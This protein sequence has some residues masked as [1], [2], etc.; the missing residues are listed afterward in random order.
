MIQNISL[1]SF[2][3]NLTHLTAPNMSS[4]RALLAKRASSRLR[5][6]VDNGNF[7]ARH[8]TL[9]HRR[10]ASLFQ[11]HRRILISIINN[12]FPHISFP[13][14]GARSDDD[15]WISPHLLSEKGLRNTRNGRNVIYSP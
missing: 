14:R 8:K 9:F 2:A 4:T 1:P 11:T 7:R 13:F 10:E 12:Y 5:I 3:S 15:L 6:K